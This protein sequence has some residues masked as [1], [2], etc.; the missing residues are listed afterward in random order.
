MRYF[1]NRNLIIVTVAAVLIIGLHY[2]GFLTRVENGVTMAI[3]PLARAVFK[4]G[5][6]LHDTAVETEDRQSL[7]ESVKNLTER[8]ETLLA[9]NI[10][11]H[12]LKN[13]NDTLREQLDFYARYSYHKQLANIV[14]RNNEAS[15]E[16][17]I[18]IDAGRAAGIAPGQIVIAG[19]GL[20]VGKIT[21]VDE[22][23]SHACLLTDS[24]C[25]LAVAVA[26][27]SGPSGLTQGELG[28]TV[29]LDFVPQT[30][31]LTAG[32]TIITSGLEIGIPAGLVIGE[33]QEVRTE[34]NNLFQTAVINPLA[35][36]QRLNIVSVIIN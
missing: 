1:F 30:T 4:S 13:E 23:L 18:T 7:L 16:R 32:D 19:A 22:Y 5:V 35:D 24:N 21:S 6:S 11:L 26:G 14:S 29:R 25:H 8:N 17:F 28:L 9:E 3:N 27:T 33:V 2:A 15:G 34:D 20:V 12:L 31:K 36:T 10:S